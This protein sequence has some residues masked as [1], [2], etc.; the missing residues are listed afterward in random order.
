MQY[1]D[2]VLKL[3][4]MLKR[5]YPAV[6]ALFVLSL[7][8]LTYYAYSWLQSIGSPVAA[9]DHYNYYA[10]FSWAWLFIST[11]ILL[12]IANILLWQSRRGWAM[13]ATLG[14]FIV[15]L[16]VR[17]F[18]LDP[19]MAAF[20]DAKGLSEGAASGVGAFLTLSL[21]IAAAAVVF[22][23]HFIVLRMAD[24]IHPVP[25]PAIDSFENEPEDS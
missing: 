1:L 7:C 17:S 12:L 23:A 14:Y 25:V 18:W 8:F 6:L 15:F 10:G 21:I 22:F 24:K 3:A 9:A 5:I 16:A 4:I 19:A 20:V 11:V 2:F 13:W